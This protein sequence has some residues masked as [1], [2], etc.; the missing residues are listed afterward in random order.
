MSVVD[1]CG[2]APRAGVLLEAI[3]LIG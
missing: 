3:R 2:I 1:E